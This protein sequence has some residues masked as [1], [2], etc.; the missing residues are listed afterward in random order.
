M[1]GAISGVGASTP[2]VEIQKPATVGAKASFGESLTDALNT[3]QQ[4]NGEAEQKIQDLL[5]G[6]GEE[7][8]K[9]M[10]AVEK[11][12]VAFEMMMQ[13]RNKIIQAYQDVSRMQF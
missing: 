13:V 4:A 3:V 6:N 11:A 5:A 10:I 2:I 7:I 12:D 1:S 8:H 9:T